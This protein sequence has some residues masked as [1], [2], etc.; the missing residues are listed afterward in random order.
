MSTDGS[1]LSNKKQLIEKYG[2]FLSAT[3]PL[4]IDCNIW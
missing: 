3:E 2:V 4:G 1:F